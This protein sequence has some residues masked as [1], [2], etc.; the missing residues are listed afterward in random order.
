MF[1]LLW[2]L[3][4]LQFWFAF[5]IILKFYRFDEI[6][7]GW[8]IATT[9][10]VSVKKLIRKWSL[11]RDCKF[12]L[13]LYDPFYHNYFCNASV[14]NGPWKVVVSILLWSS[15]FFDFGWSILQGLKNWGCGG[16]WRVSEEDKD[17]WGEEW[18]GN[19]IKMWKK[20]EEWRKMKI[21]QRWEIYLYQF[22]FSILLEIQMK[23]IMK[24][25]SNSTISYILIFQFHISLCIVRIGEME[26]RFELQA[27][28]SSK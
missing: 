1:P 14:S 22:L 5:L 17:D 15:K 4:L 12:P 18:K 27:F 16:G 8:R 6:E 3:P 9:M 2:L 11:E 19:R 25:I 26:V 23:F 28:F 7:G 21:E 10:R 24:F 20:S 13:F